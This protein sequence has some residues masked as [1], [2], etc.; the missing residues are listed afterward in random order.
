[1]PLLSGCGAKKTGVVI[2][3]SM[4]S[5]RNDALSQ[6]LKEK[7]PDIKVTVQQLSTGNSAAKIQAEGTST[8]A[9]IVLGLETALYDKLSENFAALDTMFEPNDYLDDFVNYPCS[10]CGSLAH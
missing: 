5:Y 1:M 9:D 7:F 10:N 2:F 6:Q 8:E 3:S 4:E